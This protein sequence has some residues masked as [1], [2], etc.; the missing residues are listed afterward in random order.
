MLTEV[1]C[2]N[3]QRLLLLVPE[4]N[5]LATLHISFLLAPRDQDPGI[6]IR[7]PDQALGMGFAAASRHQLKLVHEQDV[8][9][10]S[11]LVAKKRPRDACLP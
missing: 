3:I 6:V 9:I 4:L 7:I 2:E 8:A 1:Q 10:L 11:S 5:L